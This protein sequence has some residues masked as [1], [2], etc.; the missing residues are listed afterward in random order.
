MKTIITEIP[1]YKTFYRGRQTVEIGYP[2]LSFGAIIALEKIMKDFAGKVNVLEIG[3]GG[4]TVFFLKNGGTVDSYEDDSEWAKR[5]HNSLYRL[6]GS[7]LSVVIDEPL[8]IIRRLRHESSD[9]DIVLVDGFSGA[10]CYNRRQMALDVSWKKVKKG[11]WLII[12]NYEHMTFDET[13]WDVYT[14][15]MFH[16]SGR[17]TK[18]LRRL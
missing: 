6:S 17:G 18:L 2:W 11:G 8:R 1:D 3:M 16:Y 13:G 12:D 10:R 14:F 5:V 9:Y 7:N 4:S 15:D